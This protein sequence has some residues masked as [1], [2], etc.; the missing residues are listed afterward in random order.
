MR[1][2]VPRGWLCQVCSIGP[3]KCPID[4][5]F[6]V[7]EHSQHSHQEYAGCLHRWRLLLVS[8]SVHWS[9]FSY[10]LSHSLR[11]IGWGL[12]YGD[13]GNAF[14]G[15]SQYFNYQL[16]YEQYPKWFFQ[17]SY[18]LLRVSPEGLLFSSCS[19]PLLPQSYPEPLLSDA[20]SSPTSPT[21]SS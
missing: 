12:A 16:D 17:V 10:P 20:S 2:C 19:L 6:Q 13:G 1:I 15:G 11:A 4:S 5:I 3:V 18:S 8:I 7:K 14:C 9:T 21:R